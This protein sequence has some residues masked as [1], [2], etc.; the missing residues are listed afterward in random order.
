MSGALNR[1][2]AREAF[3]LAVFGFT[4]LLVA[5]GRS[6]LDDA[7][8]AGS[9]HTSGFSATG[10]AGTPAIGDA[11]MIA[12]GGAGTVAT[13]AAGSNDQSD[14]SP[15]CTTEIAGLSKELHVSGQA[16]TVVVRLDFQ[17]RSILGYQVICAPARTGVSEGQAFEMAVVET[18]IVETNIIPNLV[19][20]SVGTPTDEFVFFAPPSDIGGV[21]AVSATTG[22]SVFGGTIIFGGRGEITY[23]MTWR[24]AVDLSTGC[25][26]QP[27]VAPRHGWNALAQAPLSVANVD[28]A[29]LVVERTAIPAAFGDGGNVASV[30]VL[31]YPRT[32]GEPEAT[33]DATAEWIVMLN[34]E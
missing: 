3:P 12:T 23:P 28:A 26:S 7:G 33:A 2:K 5:C 20:V 30:F 14:S 11:G 16:C 10:A 19:S 1:P 25:P 13:G 22:Q 18:N 32:V 17:M 34:G 21:A 24:A 15:G 8:G 9:T 27:G 4:L 31:L 6:S 29:D